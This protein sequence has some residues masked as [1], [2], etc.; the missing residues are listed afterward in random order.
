MLFRDQIAAPC[1]PH[2]K[3][4]SVFIALAVS[5]SPQAAGVN[6][7]LA[8]HEDSEADLNF[9]AEKRLQTRVAFFGD[10]ACV[11]FSIV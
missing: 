11:V 10:I 3:H 7:P 9:W 5:K 1:Q 4:L 8:Q 2:P 6:S